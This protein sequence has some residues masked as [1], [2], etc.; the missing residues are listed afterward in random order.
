MI[1]EYFYSHKSSPIYLITRSATVANM[2]ESVST[3]SMR[4]PKTDSVG[5]VEDLLTLSPIYCD[6]TARVR[7]PIQPR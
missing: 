4:T 2:A 3:W 6:V 1:I 5:R 7:M